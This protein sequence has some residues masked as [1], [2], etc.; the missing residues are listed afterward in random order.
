MEGFPKPIYGARDA[1]KV[2]AKEIKKPQSGG[3]IP[4]KTSVEIALENITK[5][6]DAIGPPVVWTEQPAD[7]EAKLADIEKRMAVLESKIK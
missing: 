6:L 1:A 3:I 5:R 4:K 2:T 7:I